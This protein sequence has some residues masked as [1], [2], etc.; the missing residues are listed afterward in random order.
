MN[1]KI[2]NYILLLFLCLTLNSCLNQYEKEVIG[3]Y[4]LYKYELINSKVE[5]YEFTKLI[6]KKD[7][8]FE[9]KLENKIINGKWQANDNGDWTYI[10]LEYKELKVEGKI[11]GNSIHFNGNIFKEFQ[12]FKTIE[13]TKTN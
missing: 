7:K 13:F 1:S 3:N 12:N 10:V 5:A 6:I 11:G 2:I 4:E 9:I 8:T